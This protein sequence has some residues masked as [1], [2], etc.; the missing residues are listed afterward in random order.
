M[1]TH[2]GSR[3]RRRESHNVDVKI[4][5]IYEDLASENDEVR[6][7]G[8]QELVSRFT[9]ESKPTEEQVQKALQRLFR[10]L[11][12]GRKAARI[13]FSIALTEVLAQVF[14]SSGQHLAELNVPKVL[15]IW[16]LVTDVGNSESGQVRCFPLI[17]PDCNAEFPSLGAKRPLL[18]QTLRSR[19]HL[20]VID[21][22]F[23]R[24]SSEGMVQS[25]HNC[26]RAW[27][28][29]ALASG[30]MW[31]GSLPVGLRA[32]VSESWFEVCRDRSPTCLLQRTCSDT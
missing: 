14:S 29:E 1:S 10:G 16:E 22:V 26:C 28:K 20:Q 15:E 13:G 6:L 30:R 11:C 8:A 4:V 31:L 19:G 21:P 9:P 7:K 2:V 25:H 18:W 32:C 12:S 5:E 24:R 17:F 3:K 27:K 23:L